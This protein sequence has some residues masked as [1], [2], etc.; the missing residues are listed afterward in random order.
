M[1]RELPGFR[2]DRIELFNWGTFHKK[3]WTFPVGG[4]NALLTGEIGVGKSSLVDAVTTLLVSPKRLQYNQAAGADRRERSFRSYVLGYYKSE[5]ADVGYAAKPVSL[6]GPNDYSVILAHFYN[7]HLNASVSLA[8]VFWM[9]NGQEQPDRFYVVATRDLTIVEH[10]GE[11][12]SNV[13]DLKRR[14]G[15]TPDL[16]VHDTFKD[17]ELQFL[18]YFGLKHRQPLDL[19]NQAVSLKKVDNLDDFIRM[20]TLEPF[21]MQSRIDDLLTHFDNLSRAHVAVLKAKNQLVMLKPIVEG[22]AKLTRV[23]EAIGRWRRAEEALYP[24][25]A[26]LRVDLLRRHLN[27]LARE[28]D[29]LEQRRMASEGQLEETRREASRLEVD[30]DANGGQRI[31]QIEAEIHQ[32]QAE[33][34]RRRAALKEYQGYAQEVGLL[35][36]TDVDTF[37]ENRRSLRE[38]HNHL[39]R[40]RS[41]LER[42]VQKLSGDLR[43]SENTLKPLDQELTSLKQR[44]SN[45]PGDQI[46]LRRRLCAALSLSE[47][48]VPFVGE[49]LEVRSDAGAWE[50]AI[51][52]LLHSF[53]LSLVVPEEL[54]GQVAAWVDKTHL[55][56]RLVYYRVRETRE[57]GSVSLKPH[58]VPTKLLVKPD[59]RYATWLAGELRQRFNYV[60]C[61]T[62]DEFRREPAAIT[63]TGQIKGGRDRHEKDDRYRIDDRRRYVLGWDNLRKVQVLERE[64][65]AIQSRLKDITATLRDVR[66]QSLASQRK[67]AALMGLERFSDFSALDWETVA[68]DIE[69]LSR[70]SQA[71]KEGSDVLRILQDR[72]QTVNEAIQRL[73]AERNGV[74]AK[75]GANQQRQVTSREQL[76]QSEAAVR[77]VGEPER[78]T[79]FQELADIHHEEWLD[80]GTM[81]ECYEIERTLGQEI[82]RR[83]DSDGQREKRISTDIIKAMGKFRNAFPQ[84]TLEMDADVASLDDFKKMLDRISR[85]DLPRFEARFKTLLNQNTIRGIVQLQAHL[86]QQRDQIRERLEQ[87]NRSMKGLDYNAGRYIRIE[88]DPSPDRDIK[89]FQMKLRACAEDTLTG[90]AG[91]QYSEAKFLQVK[92]IIERFRGRD[93]LAEVDRRWTQKVTDVRNEFVFSASERYRDNDVEYEHYADSGGKSGGQKEKL[94]YTILAASLAYQFGLDMAGARSF[95]FVVIDE[96]FGRGSDDSARYGLELFEHLGLQLLIVTPLQKIPIIEPYVATVGFVSNEDGRASQLRTITVEEYRAEKEARRR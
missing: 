37:F 84:D 64:R 8:Q 56:G 81:Q 78:A 61:D 54:Y 51:E 47:S 58:S 5:R 31:G 79:R 69:A 71:L 1:A 70:E 57:S 9:K 35:V 22:G 59:A 41:D 73:D 6:R 42:D 38:S 65:A 85:D 89:E 82:R 29:E 34:D 19:F 72:L 20:H 62:L 94:A 28:A 17:Y 4:Q 76:T 26:S 30:I 12:G 7:Q 33:H 92:E 46:E 2:L 95:R 50:G 39:E 77:A 13:Q 80:P 45:I 11:F 90:S 16:T 87:I 63:R 68:R 10:F 25:V 74:V 52:R 75:Q 60:C 44:K 14:L 88:A 48:D 55:A 21:D 15:L 27:E 66:D 23:Q 67:L 36:P 24:Y 86:V 96:A 32:K 43:E 91:E 53:G 18:R 40:Q 83:I 93:G 3:V 49:L